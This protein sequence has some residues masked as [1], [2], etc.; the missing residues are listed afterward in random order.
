MQA[1]SEQ[2]VRK[3]LEEL[4]SS[5]P[6]PA[7]NGGFGVPD[8][9]FDTLPG[10]IQHRI[11]EHRSHRLPALPFMAYKKLIPAVV[12]LLLLVSLTA[13]LFLLR[14]AAPPAYLAGEEM[15]SEMDYLAMETGIDRGFFY[16]VVLESGLSADEIL[17]EL[18]GIHLLDADPDAYLEIMEAMFENARYYGI[19]SGYL[20]SSLD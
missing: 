13:G 6:G 8:R 3:E 20:L 19:E 1:N 16:D 11:L 10:L 17:F 9:Y 18:N 2:S 7:G 14:N 5:L 15:I 4:S 12:V